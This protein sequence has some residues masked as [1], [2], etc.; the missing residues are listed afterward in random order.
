MLEQQ[1][2][3]LNALLTQESYLIVVMDCCRY[4]YFSQHFQNYMSGLLHKT[5]SPASYTMAWLNAS[6]NRPLR[7]TL[8]ISA[9]MGISKTQWNLDGASYC[10]ADH[11]GDVIDGWKPGS[12]EGMHPVHLWNAFRANCDNPMTVAWCLQPHTPYVTQPGLE[13]SQG[14]IALAKAGRWEE[15]RKAYTINLKLGLEFVQKIVQRSPAQRIVV[16]ADHGELLGEDGKFGHNGH[17]NHPI[18]RTVPWFEVE[19]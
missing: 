11:F 9:H 18:L 1:F 7:D 13:T 2:N 4:D 8:M 3:L 19:K 16:T 15:L 14:C 10:A 5:W 6:F 17:Q 12:H